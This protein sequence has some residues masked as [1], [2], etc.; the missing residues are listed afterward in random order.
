MDIR[1]FVS[2]SFGQWRSQRSAHHLTFQHFEAVESVIDIAPMPLDNPAL[3]QLCAD[4]QVNPL[5]TVMPFQ[6]AWEGTSDWDEKAEILKGETILV[7]VPDS[8]NSSSGRL[9]RSQGYAETMPAVGLYS[10]AE[11]GTFVL[12]TQYDHAAAEEK[13][14]FHNPNL[15]FRL[16]LVKTSQGSGVVSASFSSELRVLERS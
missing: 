15:R 2:Q 5:D 10:F 8:P 11:D 6:M 1:S 4:Y 12:T 16:S 13:I 9:L 3:L 7:P 14:W